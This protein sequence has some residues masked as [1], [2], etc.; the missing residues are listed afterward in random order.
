[1]VCPLIS[2]GGFLSF[3][4]RHHYSSLLVAL[5]SVIQ[6]IVSFQEGFRTKRSHS[7][8]NGKERIQRSF[9]HG[10]RTWSVSL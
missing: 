3:V 5:T 6:R 8:S 2:V 9:Y 4:S 10:V 1:M 7:L